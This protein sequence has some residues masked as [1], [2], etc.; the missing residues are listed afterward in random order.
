MDI[1]ALNKYVPLACPDTGAFIGW[2]KLRGNYIAK[3]LI[4]EDARRSSACGRKCR[5]DMAVCLEIERLD[6][7]RVDID[8]VPSMW[9]ADFIYEVG[10]KLTVANFDD[11]RT[12]ECA[13]GIHFFITRVEAV[14]YDL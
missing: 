2:K 7:S 13:P 10:K 8:K 12:R 9:D 3:L 6:G 5:C 1:D 4:P 11:D 14:N